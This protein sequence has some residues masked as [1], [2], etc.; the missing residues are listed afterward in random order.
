M[1]TLDAIFI[2]RKLMEKHFERHK[3]LFL[4]KVSL[5]NASDRV[6][7]EVLFWAMRRN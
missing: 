2:V 6:P 1:G 3:D 7:R 4:T 5:E